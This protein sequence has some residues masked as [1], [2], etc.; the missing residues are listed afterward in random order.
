MIVITGAAGFISSAL[1]AKLNE[2]R[3]FN[4]ILVDDFSREDRTRNYADKQ[5]TA[6]VDREQFPQWLREN[7]NQVEFIFHLGA[8]TDTTEFDREIFDKL[9]VNYTKEIWNLCI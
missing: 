9:N 8:R 1:V 6:L 3:F 7:E 2:E 4:L 5:Y